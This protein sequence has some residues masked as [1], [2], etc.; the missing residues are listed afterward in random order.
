MQG[1]L[2]YLLMPI[3]AGLLVVAQACWGSV[4]KNQHALRGTPTTIASNLISNPRM[5]LGAFIYIIATLL[6]FFL[7]S[8]L[9]FFSVQVAMTGLSIAFSTLLA[10]IYFHENIS[11]L[12]IVGAAVILCGVALV[13]TK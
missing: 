4:I 2:P 1:I 10:Y 6:Y 8:K 9:R 13:V 11:L 3:M 7:L 5:W 12:N